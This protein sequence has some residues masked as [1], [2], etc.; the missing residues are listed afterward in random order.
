MQENLTNFLAKQEGPIRIVIHFRRAANER[1]D[2]KR[3]LE[4]KKDVQLFKSAVKAAYEYE[5]EYD[6]SLDEFAGTFSVGNEKTVDEK[7][8]LFEEPSSDDEE[9]VQDEVSLELK[10]VRVQWSDNCIKAVGERKANVKEEEDAEEEQAEE[11]QEENAEG[12]PTPG[13]R[14]RGFLRGSGVNTR[15]TPRGGRGSKK[16][17]S[18]QRAKSHNRKDQSAKKRGGMFKP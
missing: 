8:K 11:A 4:D 18:Y 12:T 17:A 10:Q 16:S 9:D 15:G 13:G 3:I 14:G 6:D 7:L 5:D 1:E 2:A